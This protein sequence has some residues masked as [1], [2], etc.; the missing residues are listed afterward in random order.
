MIGSY[1]KKNDGISPFYI[2][3]ESECKKKGVSIAEMAAACG[4]G[5]STAYKWKGDTVPYGKTLQTIASYLGTTS[6][7]LL[8]GD[9]VAAPLP[10]MSA[11][12]TEP[13]SGSLSLDRLAS[14]WQQDRA[15]AKIREDRLFGLLAERQGAEIKSLSDKVE[16]LSEMVEK[17]TVKIENQPQKPLKNSD[18]PVAVASPRGLV[19][20]K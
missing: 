7:Y 1:D 17:L 8:N 12:E 16:K 6:D 9:A 5:T 10:D 3:L 2:R 14:L 20:K 13:V 19:V 11:P 15:E 18:S 4:L